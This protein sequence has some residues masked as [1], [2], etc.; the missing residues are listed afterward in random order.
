MARCEGREDDVD[1][2]TRVTATT[3]PRVFIT[4]AAGAGLTPPFLEPVEL[5]LLLGLEEI[6]ILLLEEAET[7]SSLD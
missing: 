4:A 2:V 6:K 5:E 1:L 3:D 7:P